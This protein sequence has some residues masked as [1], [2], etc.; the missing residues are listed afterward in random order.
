MK[1]FVVDLS[2]QKFGRL[3]VVKWGGKGQWVCR[4]EC[5]KIK[6]VLTEYLHRGSTKSCGC[7]SLESSRKTKNVKH[8]FWNTNFSKGTMKFYLMWGSLKARC[9]NSNLKCYKN[10][11]GRG[12]TYDKRWED[13]SGFRKDMYFKYLY[14]TKQLKL[15]RP[16]IERID[17]NGNYCKENCTFISFAGQMQNSRAVI[18]FIA[19][20]P[21]GEKFNARNVNAFSKEYSLNSSHVYECLYGKA[22]HHKRWKFKIL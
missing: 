8:G 3:T 12:I 7:L 17:V 20:S 13:F 15:E 9:N 22:N 14:A 19:I 21:E 16:S 6:R 10:Y 4:C 1:K 18:S 11:G 2:R 5:G